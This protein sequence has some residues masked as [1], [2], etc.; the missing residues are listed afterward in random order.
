MTKPDKSNN[1]EKINNSDVPDEIVKR[2]DEILSEEKIPD[3]EKQKIIKLLVTSI[4]Y[5]GHSGPLPHPRILKEYYDIKDDL[6]EN[7]VEQFVE[8]A[9][10]R[11]SLLKKNLEEGHKRRSRGQWLGFSLGILYSL[12]A[13]FAIYLGETIVAIAVGCSIPISIAIALIFGRRTR[14]KSE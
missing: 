4:K 2:I 1:D 5:E 14:E 11:R 8:E 7:I 10:F 9:E 3:S 13:G 12:L 6:G